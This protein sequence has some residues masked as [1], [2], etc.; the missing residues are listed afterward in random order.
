MLDGIFLRYVLNPNMAT[1][2]EEMKTYL[3][4]LPKI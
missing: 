4:V 2:A 1:L 3:N